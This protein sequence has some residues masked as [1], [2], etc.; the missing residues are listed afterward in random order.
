[1]ASMM[2]FDDRLRNLLALARD[3]SPANRLAL[4]RHLADLLLQGRPLGDAR[5]TAAL[6]DILGQLRDEVPLSVRQDA[7]DDLLAQAARPMPLVRLL[8]TDDLAVA[9]KILDR[10]D[11]AE[12]DWLD[13]IAALPAANRR[14]LRIRADL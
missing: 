5:D 11:L 7:A 9:R 2:R 3:K 13:L 12:N 1:M 4:F 14:H 10:I 6:L 8:A